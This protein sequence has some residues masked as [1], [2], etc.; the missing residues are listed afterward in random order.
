MIRSRFLP[1]AAI[2]ALSVVAYSQTKTTPGTPRVVKPEDL[3]ALSWRSIGPANMGGRVADICL[4]PGNGKSFFVAYGIGGLWKTTNRGNTLSPVFDH[5]ITNSIG[6]VV[7]ADAPATWAG[8]KDSKDKPEDLA[9]KGKAKIVWVG[10]GEGNGRNSS[11]WG[12]GVY[13]STD[14]GSSFTNVGLEESHDIPR[15][16]V[17]PRNPD[18]CYAAA[19]GHLWG[20][21][22]MRGLYKTEDG[23]KTWKPVLQIDQDTGAIDVILDPSNP[24]TVYAGMYMRRRTPYSFVSGGKEGGVYKSTDA[25]KTWAK[26]TNGLP[27]QSGRIGLDL[28]RKN[29]NIVYAVV[30][31]DVG[32]GSNIDDE[33]SRSGGL[34]RSDDAGKTWTRI[35][36]RV[37][38]AF[39][40]A[41]VR[42]DPEDDQRVYLIGY[43]VDISDDG[44]HAFRRG[45][46]KTH[47]DF[48][49][50]VI[51]PDDHEHR[52][53]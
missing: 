9:K 15:L 2:A 51:D 26:L 14:G 49:A 13:R 38:R 37:P 39:Y 41:K 10:S 50:L 46:E 42:V 11:S 17:D 34:F 21:N 32:G 40:F 36:G 35:H 27:K 8:W 24:D 52:L 25:G 48:H 1:L 31:S 19:M 3:K 33:R 12:H 43:G 20:P 4:A 53:A 45:F 5:E 16:A 47:G 44:G 6:S 23:G 7:V 29:P 22:K 30:E 28:Y 18:I